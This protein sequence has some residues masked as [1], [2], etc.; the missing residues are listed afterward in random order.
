MFIIKIE[1]LEFGDIILIKS[2]SEVSQRVRQLSGSE[3]SHAMLYVGL[4]SY[5]DS[6]GTGVQGNNIQRKLFKSSDDVK[7]LRVK[8]P[9]LKDKL[10]SITNFAR[11]KIGTEYSI[12]E[13]FTAIKNSSE[14]E[15]QEPNRQFCT[16]FVSQAYNSSGIK[17]TENADY[18]LPD[19]LLKSEVLSEVPNITREA[20]KAEIDFADSESPLQNQIEIH[21]S[22]FNYIRTISNKDIQTFEQLE[23]LLKSNQEFDDRITN[24]VRESGYLNMMDN[25]F[26]KNP[27]HYYAH[28]LEN[29]YK[30][31]SLNA[32]KTILRIDI[33][34][35]DGYKFT[36]NHF[37]NLNENIPRQYF[38]MQMDLL[39]RLIEYSKSRI[40]AAEEIWEKFNPTEKFNSDFDSRFF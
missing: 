11:T 19:D 7:V 13:A 8:N 3:F 33:P 31:D 15:A 28:L 39:S 24:F 38:L 9:L 36:M 35:L 21:N 20:N 40:A 32:A 6:D 34:L 12:R 26:E 29:F 5:I 18:C 25:D 1:L 4:S 17:L 30:Q 23:E 37:T 22:I 16:R 14:L 27:Q 10:V 2:D